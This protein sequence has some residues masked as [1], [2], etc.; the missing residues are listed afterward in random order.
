MSVHAL[1]RP[2]KLGPLF[3]RAVATSRGRHGDT[4]APTVYE[5][6]AQPID[7]DHL[8]AY[9]RVCGFRIGNVLPATYLHVLAFPLSVARMVERDFPFP[10]IG[11][12]HI[13]NSITQLRPVT[14]GESVSL[15]VE[16]AN[17]RPHAA[18]QQLDILSTASV[19]GTEV[20]TSTSTYLRRDKQPAE[21][22]TRSPRPE[23][24]TGPAMTIRVPA[25]IGRRY[26]AVAGDRNPIHLHAWSAKAFGFPSAIA[27]GMWLQARALA[28]LEGRLP[29]AFTV[30]AAFKTPVFLPST[31]ELVSAR[32]EDGWH[33][34]VHNAKSSKPHLTSTVR[35]T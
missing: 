35:P 13:A 29:E 15:R 17:L 30:D 10:L 12:V 4:I 32:V 14:L 18:G 33:L 5:L 34:D 2:P 7:S 11:L 9:Q 21:R 8:A 27:H 23:T 25:D 3:A 16:A 26:A 31:V 22:P 19:D 20:W 24:P 28:T 1:D 6:A